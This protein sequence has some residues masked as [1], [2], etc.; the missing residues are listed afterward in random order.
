[1][2]RYVYLYI[3]VC[4][5]KAQYILDKKH[6]AKVLNDFLKMIS[7]ALPSQADIC[8]VQQVSA[9]CPCVS[10]VAGTNRVIGAERSTGQPCAGFVLRV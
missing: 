10:E 5:Q 7:L 2:H 4:I 3:Y 8:E 1:M 9:K 6:T